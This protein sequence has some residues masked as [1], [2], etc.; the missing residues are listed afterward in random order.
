MWHR[1]ISNLTPAFALLIGYI[2]TLLSCVGVWW[3]SYGDI[4][5]H[6][7]RTWLYLGSYTYLSEPRSLNILVRSKISCVTSLFLK[8]RP[9]IPCLWNASTLSARQTAKDWPYPLTD[10]LSM[11]YNRHLMRDNFD[12]FF[13]LKYPFWRFRNRHTEWPFRLHPRC[14]VPQNKGCVLVYGAYSDAEP[15]YWCQSNLGYNLNGHPVLSDVH[16]TK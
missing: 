3:F 6:I 9:C 15:L 5:T 16:W 7:K 8:L 11:V 1:L 4:K 13:R 14:C 2:V 10:T 12:W